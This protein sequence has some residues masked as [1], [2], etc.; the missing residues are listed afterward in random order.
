LL[1]DYG[2]WCP[3]IYRSVYIDRHNDTHALV[4]PCC[5]AASQLE[6]VD[7]F[8]F[9]TSPYLTQLRTQFDQGQQPSACNNC[10]TVENYGHKSRRQSAI[11][12]F[13]DK[14]PNTAVQL[15][16]IDHSATW[17][18]NL[19]CI[20]CHPGSSSL[21]ASQENLTRDDL[22][23]IGRLFQKSN[24]FLDKLDVSH[25]KK[26]HFNGG[27]PMLNND[28]TDLLLKLKEQGVLKNTF[29][30][31][32]TNGTVMPSQQVIDL[33]KQA[34]LVKIF[35]SIDAVGS[36]FEYV[37]WPGKWE[38]TSKNILDMRATL[39]NNVMFG[40]NTT[41]GNYNVLE[42]AEVYD[43]FNKHI[44]TNK[45][46]DPSDFCWQLA[47]NFDPKELSKIIKMQAI[48]ELEPLAELNGL[49]EYLRAT[50]NIPENTAWVTTLDNLDAKRN[51]NWRTALKI[52]QF[53]KE[54]HC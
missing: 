49:V 30:S 16:S 51:T 4:A 32:N 29:I 39:P 36:A 19:A 1:K 31:Y 42:I 5:Q 40:F 25:I 50:L 6:P 22:K 3:E 20:M 43:W 15:Q 21:W 10:W 23:A 47:N 46:G 11:E 35:F 52:T 27:E 45:E 44:Q 18:C 2:N 53:I 28:Q 13:Q 54:S 17:A 14:A 33:W 26:I 8:D 9:K 24:N 34:R 48:N 41:V 37:R 12:F 38:Q 7:T